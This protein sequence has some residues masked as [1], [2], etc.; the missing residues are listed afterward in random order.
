M[1]DRK[2]RVELIKDESDLTDSYEC[3]RASFGMQM[4]DVFWLATN[5]KHDTPQ[6]HAAGVERLARRWRETKDEGHCYF[7]KA[8]VTEHDGTEHIG[9]MAIWTEQSAERNPPRKELDETMDVTT[10]GDEK[11][12]RFARQM[13]ASFMRRRS[14]V[15]AEAAR[16]GRSIMV[17][18]LCCVHPNFQKMGLARKLV[19]WG[20]D[21]AARL[22]DK[23][24]GLECFTEAS[25]M[26]RPV[27][28]KMGFQ[29]DSE[30][31][32]AMDDEFKDRKVAPNTHLRR[33]IGVAY[34]DATS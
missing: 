4:R 6:G 2:S 15:V 29:F 21:Q 23:G 34:K 22:G 10:L 1:A 28:Q 18:D 7:L 3:A 30:M 33:P 13:F 26:G 14:E 9:G 20:L 17:L 27:Y 8:I 25:P 24:Q 11:E 19:Q 5:P 16:N 31:V 32:Y 12:Q